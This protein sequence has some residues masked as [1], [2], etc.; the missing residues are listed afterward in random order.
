MPRPTLYDIPP[1]SQHNS[2]AMN[3][4]DI[5]AVP[6]YPLPVRKLPKRERKS[7]VLWA[8]VTPEDFRTVEDY[9]RRHDQFVSSL[10]REVVL[11]HVKTTSQ[12][13]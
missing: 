11:N 13:A 6:G 12:T 8:R 3:P 4:I 9:A 2:G 7:A 1:L 5:S 10:I